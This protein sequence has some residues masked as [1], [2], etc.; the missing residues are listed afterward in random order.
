MLKKI[1][2]GLFVGP[3]IKY[4]R[5]ANISAPNFNGFSDE[6]KPAESKGL[7][8]S[9]LKDVRNSLLTPTTG[10]YV[11]L[12]SSYVFSASN[13]KELMLD[14]RIYKTWRDRLTLA[15]R[16]VT[17]INI[18]SPPFYDFAFLGGDKFVRGYYYGRFRD[19]NLSNIQTE[20]RGRVYKIIGMSLFGGLARL[21]TEKNYLATSNTK[22]NYGLGLRVV[23]DKKEK[24]NLRLD[25]AIGSNGN[26]GF[27]IS[28]GE[29]F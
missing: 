3:N 16:F 15:T 5:Y 10:Y 4:I 17:D 9:I 12:N 21:S 1:G 25:Y 13:Y 23:M 2:N 7:G 18:G 26:N 20:F 28:F 11:F 22:Y 6:L 24:T 14:A 27:Y 8:L 29:S 19:K